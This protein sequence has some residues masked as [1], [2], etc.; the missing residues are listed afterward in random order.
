VSETLAGRI[1]R[2]TLWPLSQGEIGRRPETFL[3]RLLDAD[4]ATD[5]ISELD[6]RDYLERALTGGYLEARARQGQRRRGGSAR[7]SR[8]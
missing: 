1:E 5:W 4:L 7:M 3:S 2:H 8:R 6:N